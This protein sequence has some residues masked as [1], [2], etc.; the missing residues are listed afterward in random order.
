MVLIKS[1]GVRRE[2]GAF[3][4]P[5]DTGLLLTLYQTEP[6]ARLSLFHINFDFVIIA[7]FKLLFIKIKIVKIKLKPTS[8]LSDPS[9]FSTVI[10][11][12]HLR[13]LL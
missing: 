10:P 4:F 3:D 1:K 8:Q 11:L 9:A 5:H 7:Y 6:Q 12:T 13:A 2:A